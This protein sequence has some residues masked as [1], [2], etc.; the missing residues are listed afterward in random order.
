VAA[1]VLAGSILYLIRQTPLYSSQAKVLVEAVSL[2]TA[3]A[4]Q[5]TPPNINTEE[6][7]VDSA[8]VARVVARDLKLKANVD[9]ILKQLSVS[10]P[11]DTEIL[12]IS[13]R[14]PRPREAQRRAQAFAQAYLQLR[15]QR[16][17]KDLAALADPIDRRIQAL[18]ANLQRL[19]ARIVVAKDP[20]A[21]AGL[22]GQA[23]SLETR[24]GLLEQSRADLT[25]SVGLSVGQI[26]DP[27]DLPT[28]PVNRNYPLT[29]S[30]AIFLG[31]TLGVGVALVRDRLDDHLRSEPDLE[32][33]SRA[34]TMGIIP[35]MTRELEN[36]VLV[37]MLSPSAESF[38]NL[39]A[40]VMFATTQQSTR[41]MV[42]TSPEAGNGKTTVAANLGV[43]LAQS[44]QRVALVS[45]DLKK[46]RLDQFFGLNG[47]PG[48]TSV[49]IGGVTALQALHPTR[50][51]KLSVM[52]TGPLRP[53]SGEL[54]GSDR[55]RHL[56][57]DVRET[58]DLVLIDAP[59]ILWVADSLALAGI[60]GSVLLVVDARRTTKAAVSRA[61]RQLDLANATILGTVL[62][63][64]DPSDFRHYGVAAEGY[65]YGYSAD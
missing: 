4:G 50:M 52:G 54:L 33:S 48:V 20:L 12:F 55:M 1:L 49:L 38:R 30:V 32:A 10:S 7:L 26:E 34:V 65:G 25:P 37:D 64:F 3:Q 24:I 35:R 16:F 61:R 18:Q 40:A 60:V 6:Q 2:S 14:D 17:E 43:S 46:P 21:K 53:D 29:V 47:E 13:Y 28:S 57:E 63:N 19:Y 41:V 15:L 23:S 56:L 45:A 9:E 42:V 27:A 11:S 62:N 51:P 59:P 22:Q 5:Q 36:G 39:R 31:L 8:A 58:V 44:G